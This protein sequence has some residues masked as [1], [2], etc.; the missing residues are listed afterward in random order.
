MP[1][2]PRKWTLSLSGGE[3]GTTSRNV[4]QNLGESS[5]R[6]GRTD[7]ERTSH[8]H[9]CSRKRSVPAEKFRARRA[10]YCLELARQSAE[11]R[12]FKQHRGGRGTKG[13]FCNKKRRRRGE[14]R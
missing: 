13:A 5:A 14:R 9:W 10:E 6:K 4:R 2:A 7:S 3:T 8:G 1:V 11:Q 12:L